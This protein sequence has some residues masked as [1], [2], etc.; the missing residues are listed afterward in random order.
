LKPSYAQK[1][2]DKSLWQNRLLPVASGQGFSGTVSFHTDASI[3]RCQLDAEK[4]VIHECVEGRCAFLYLTE[5]AVSINGQVVLARD[6][7]RVN[8][9]EQLIIKAQKCSEFILIDV[10]DRTE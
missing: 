7:A 6:Q 1:N 4:G 3:Y 9:A 2:Y 8:T 5:G 10:P